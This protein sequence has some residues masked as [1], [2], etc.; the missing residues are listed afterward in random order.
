MG[1]ELPGR[2]KEVRLRDERALAGIQDAAFRGEQSVGYGPEEMNGKIGG[3]DEDIVDDGIDRKEAGVIEK[4]E[5]DR[6]V[7]RVR[8]VMKIAPRLDRDLGNAVT[9]P[10][11]WPIVRVGRC[12]DVQ[13]FEPSPVFFSLVHAAGIMARVKT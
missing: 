13:L 8:S 6:A 5:V 4:L 9:D 12:A 11:R 3:Q 1:D 10:N 2:V 7:N